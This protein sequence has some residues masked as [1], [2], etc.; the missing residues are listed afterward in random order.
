MENQ[1]LIPAKEIPRYLPV[2]MSTIRAWIAQGRLPVIRI[3][4]LVTVQRSVIERIQH[5]GLD[6]VRGARGEK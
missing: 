6:S 3:G 2:K 1:T 4:R 5:E